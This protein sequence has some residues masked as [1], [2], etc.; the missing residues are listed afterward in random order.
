ML[1]VDDPNPDGLHVA[2]N[3][4][5]KVDRP[6]NVQAAGELQIAI[7]VCNRSQRCSACGEAG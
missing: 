5:P 6:L 1:G 3:D 7:D 2:Q 4:V